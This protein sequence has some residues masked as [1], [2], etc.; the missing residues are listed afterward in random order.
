MK[1]DKIKYLTLI[2]IA[3]FFASTNEL[4]AKEAEQNF[5]TESHTFLRA[6]NLNVKI[7]LDKHNTNS[8]KVL[9]P[10]IFSDYFDFSKNY[11]TLLSANRLKFIPHSLSEDIRLKNS[12][13]LI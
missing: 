9:T 13:F 5:N 3:L 12:V 7:S 10:Y 2:L 4:S 11:F 8:A 1:A 6:D